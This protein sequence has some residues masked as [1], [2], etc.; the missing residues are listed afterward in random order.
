[1]KAPRIMK[2]GNAVFAISQVLLLAGA[3]AG[4]IPAA[5]AQLEN[6]RHASERRELRSMAR[7]L[8]ALRKQVRQLAMQNQALLQREETLERR[9]A[10]RARGSSAPATSLRDAPSAPEPASPAE[11]PPATKP[12]DSGEGSAVPESSS[13]LPSASSA[14]PAGAASVVPYDLRN[15]HPWGYG[16]IYYSHP[17]REPRHTQADLARAVIGIGYTFDARTEFNSEFEVE[18]A[19][20][21]A[22]DSGEFE[23]EQF[24]IDRRLA[25]PVSLRAGLFLMPF[26]MLNEHHEPVYYYGVERNFV[27]SLIIPSTWREGGLGLH[28]ET[29]AGLGWNAGVTTGVDLSKWNFAPRFPLYDTALDLENNDVA[30]L[31]ATHQ[32]LQLA[33]AQHLF[34]Y[35]ALDYHGLPGLTVGGAFGSGDAV[36]A[37]APAAAPIRGGERVT[38]WESHVRFTPG[39]FD[40]AALYAH[41]QIGNVA[42][43]N[44]ANPGSANPIPSDFYGWYLQGA[45]Q[46][47]QRG[48]YRLSPFV[49]W[50]TYDMGSRYEGTAGPV[51]PEGP[52]PLSAAPGDYG[53]WPRGEDRVFTTGAN[54]FITSHIVVKA[55]YQWFRVNRDFDRLDLGLGVNY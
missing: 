47:W 51:I 27:E 12:S 33:N 3:L 21:S 18:H 49:R 30:P 20:T 54:F 52:T 42:L 16:E 41:G 15:W 46:A 55:D 24:Y 9:L 38:L 25:N 45:Y 48:E 13:A 11:A 26:G 5:G 8:Q 1:M 6:P 40:L 19:V 7:E 44:E 43:A 36:K 2:T 53:L 23:V 4:P 34:G 10:Q 50:E 28:G 17:V 29:A 37:A 14:L 35:L 31:Q 32:E 22:E 39:N